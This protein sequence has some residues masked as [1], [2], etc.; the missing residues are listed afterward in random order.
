MLTPDEK[1][2]F[3]KL[4]SK[5]CRQEIDKGHCSDNECELCPINKAYDEIFYLFNDEEND[6][7]EEM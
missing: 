1:A 5:Y 2:E 4:F 7:Y 3:K 6:D